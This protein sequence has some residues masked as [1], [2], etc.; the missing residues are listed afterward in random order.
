VELDAKVD[1]DIAM[2]MIKKRIEHT[3]LM[4]PTI[5]ALLER[6]ELPS[7][8]SALGG[9]MRWRRRSSSSSIFNCR[10]I[11]NSSDSS[12][13]FACN[14]AISAADRK[15]IEAVISDGGGRDSMGCRRG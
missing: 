4:I 13:S 7:L 5:Q 9:T 2:T 11:A 10:A 14:K 8:Q 12:R 3:P 1:N 15:A 6:V